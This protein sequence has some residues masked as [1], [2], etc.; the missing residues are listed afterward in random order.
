MFPFTCVF[1]FVFQA[2][3]QIARDNAVT[4]QQRSASGR[5]IR[6]EAC[7]GTEVDRTGSNPFSEKDSGILDV[8]DEEKDEVRG[9]RFIS[10]VTI[11]PLSISNDFKPL[12]S[13]QSVLFFR[14][15]MKPERKIHINTS[16]WVLFSFSF[17]LSPL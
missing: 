9:E 13:F 14:Q 1:V 8:E 11:K 2:Q 5:R 10:G 17:C 3:V 4:S 6:K 16:F 12:S 15:F 7:S